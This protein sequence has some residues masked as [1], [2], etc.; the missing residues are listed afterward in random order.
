[1]VQLSP[2]AHMG[3]PVPIGTLSCLAVRLR[4]VY[5]TVL[6]DYSAI[7]VAIAMLILTVYALYGPHRNISTFV[8]V[9]C[10]AKVLDIDERIRQV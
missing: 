10:E 1:M 2:W 4:R 9:G 8:G 7:P 5:L 3:W 6:C